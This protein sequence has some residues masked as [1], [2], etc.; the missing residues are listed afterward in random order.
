MIFFLLYT[1][2]LHISYR[3]FFTCTCISLLSDVQKCSFTYNYLH[4]QLTDIYLISSFEDN[5][6]T[7][8]AVSKI[9]VGYSGFF[10][11]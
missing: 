10:H 7:K 2:I 6:A 8:N 1:F 5:E 3:L 11:Q 9:Y 4:K